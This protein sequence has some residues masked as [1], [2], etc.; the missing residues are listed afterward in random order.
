MTDLT[1]CPLCLAHTS[2][3]QVVGIERLIQQGVVLDG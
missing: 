2:P 3:S 1:V